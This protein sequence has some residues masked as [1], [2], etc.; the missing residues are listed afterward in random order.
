MAN[1]ARIKRTK[2]GAMEEK[3]KREKE[4]KREKKSRTTKK[5]GLPS[6][7]RRT[8]MLRR[9]EEVCRMGCDA[10]R[11]GRRDGVRWRERGVCGENSKERRGERQ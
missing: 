4:K 9:A 5:E 6:H 8:D 3:G 1:G 7:W 2:P 10:M 11:R